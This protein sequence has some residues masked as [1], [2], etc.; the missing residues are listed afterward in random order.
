MSC[1]NRTNSPTNYV[2]NYSEV[3]STSSSSCSNDYLISENACSKTNCADSDSKKHSIIR[4]LHRNIL[5]IFHF[6]RML[7]FWLF[8]LI[9][10]TSVFGQTFRRVHLGFPEAW[11]GDKYR[12]LNCPAKNIPRFLG[13]FSAPK[14]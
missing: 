1:R 2:C 12:D 13:S 3:A 6:P 11:D 14:K 4:I 8:L 5:R 10:L 9:H 7:T